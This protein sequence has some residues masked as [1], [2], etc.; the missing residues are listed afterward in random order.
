[1]SEDMWSD[2]PEAVASLDDDE[3]VRVIVLAGRGDAFT[4]GIDVHMLASLQ[5]SGPSAAARNLRVYEEIRRLQ[6]T[7]SCFADCAKPVIAAIHG[8]CLGA[9][10]NLISACDL[11]LAS[12]DARFSLRE[13]KMGL[14]ADIGALQRLPAVV[15][16]A[17]TVEMGLTGDDYDAGWAL[18][19]G[20]V[21]EVLPDRDA[22]LERALD[23][24]G[25][26]AVNSPL[27]TRGVKR[28]LQA[29]DG[30]TID[31]GLEYVAQWNSSFLLSNDLTEALTAFME[32]R[33]PVFEGE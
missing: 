15:G 27:V 33:P 26:I 23:L 21:G 28:V 13:T 9:G 7:V 1:M 22:L 6:R 11:R 14:V 8:Y 5:P 32:K 4:V 30:R 19:R 12:A 16:Q 10:L 24:A 20:L 2:I 3:A 25:R 18:G 31:Q 17:T 29:N